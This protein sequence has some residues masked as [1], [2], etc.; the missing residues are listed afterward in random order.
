MVLKLYGYV[1]STAAK[2]VAM[3]LYEK[4]IPFEYIEIDLSTKKN[5][6]EAYLAIQPFGQVPCIDDDGFILYES[7]AIARYLEEKH[8]NQGTKLI[9][10]D[11]KKRAL[12]D[13]AASI[14]AFNFD[15]YGVPLFY[16]VFV[17]PRYGKEVNHEKAKELTATLGTKLDIYEQI[18]AKQPYLS[19]DELTL[20]DL[21]HLPV[22]NVLFMA[23][24]NVISERPNVA[25]WYNNM[26]SRPSWQKVKDGLGAA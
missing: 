1:H 23:G 18:L 10:S 25:R 9:P 21:Y 17:N 12:F 13:Q 24:I 11:P 8:P 7:R 19:G 16:E 26:A 4:E 22:G 2:L 14:E 20:A 3:V 6:S 5:R 15:C